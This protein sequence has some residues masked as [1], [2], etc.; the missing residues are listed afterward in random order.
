MENGQVGHAA[1]MFDEIKAYAADAA[2]V[3]TPQLP[4]RN[5]IFD[6]GNTAIG[7]AARCDRVQGDIHLRAMAVAC[8]I[9]AR[10]MPSLRMQPPQALDR[11]IGRR[12]AAIGSVGK[13]AGRA[14]H[15]T[16]RIARPVR[17]AQSGRYRQRIRRQATLQGVFDRGHFSDVLPVCLF[18]CEIA[19]ARLGQRFAHAVYIQAELTR[20]QSFA[21]A[22]FLRF[23]GCRRRRDFPACCCGTITTPS[24]IRDHHVAGMHEGA[25]ANDGCVDRSH[26]GLHGTLGVDRFGPDGKV[27]TAQL[28]H[29]STAGVNHQ[30]DGAAGAKRGR[31]QIAEHAVG[32]LRGGGEHRHVP[33]LQQLRGHVQHPVIAGVRENRNGG[34]ARLRS[35]I[36]GPHIRCHQA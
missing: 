4:I 10:E 22:G 15:V 6:A 34:S 12:V 21:V 25:G 32:V 5:R 11:R 7:P 23:A 3:Q 30:P 9:T 8:T 27:H 36:D 19:Q 20:R 29:I 33:R 24:C 35:R 1:Q 28:R 2:I 31:Q 16:V 17:Q 26:R 18:V 14:E 13:F